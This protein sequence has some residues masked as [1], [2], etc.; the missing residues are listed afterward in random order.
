MATI[1]TAATIPPITTGFVSIPAP[2]EGK[3][4]VRGMVWEWDNEPMVSFKVMV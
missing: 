2:D 3:V 4:T 1:A